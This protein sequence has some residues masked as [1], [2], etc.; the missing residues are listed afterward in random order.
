MSKNS[1]PGSRPT[2]PGQYVVLSYCRIRSYQGL[3][4]FG[5]SKL[6]PTT[7][8]WKKNTGKFGRKV[9]TGFPEHYMHLKDFSGHKFLMHLQ[10][11]WYRNPDPAFHFTKLNFLLTED[12]FPYPTFRTYKEYLGKINNIF[13]IFSVL[14]N[15]YR[16]IKMLKIYL[17][18]S[19]ILRSGSWELL[20]HIRIW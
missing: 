8:C 14:T 5:S 17:P 2:Q 20:K 10:F 15:V 13:G 19:R 7:V 16:Y 1:I 18:C 11:W 4:R 9:L 6:L 12:S 3:C